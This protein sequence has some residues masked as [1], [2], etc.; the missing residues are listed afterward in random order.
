MVL[1]E[2]FILG[3]VG[4]AMGLGASFAATRLMSGL[5]FGVDPVDPITYGTVAVALTGITLL[6]SYLPAHRA[7]RVDP[8]EALRAE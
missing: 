6:A 3:G 8:I 5:L 7:A 4:V 2:G 1:R